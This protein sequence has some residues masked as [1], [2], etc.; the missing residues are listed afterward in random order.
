MFTKSARFY[1]ALYSWKD[2]PAEAHYIKETVDKRAPHAVSLLDVA[3]GTG[4]HLEH[5][6]DSFQVSGLD[7]D[8]ELLNIAR[9]RVPSADLH[10]GDMSSFD[11]GRRFDVVICMFSSIGYVRSLDRLRQAAYALATHMEPGGLLML[12][13][14]FGPG[15]FEDGRVDTLVGRSDDLTIER[16]ARSR[17]EG[18]DSIID[19]DYTVA[20]SSGVRERFSEHHVLGLFTRQEY[21]KAIEGAGLGHLEWDERGPTGR[22]L[23]TATKAARVEKRSFI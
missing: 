17:L 14:W 4:A 6:V 22:G 20:D 10:L 9:G 23:V 2:Y 5:L 11:L 16:V 19:F 13:P 1:D 18:R 21:N 3:C 15:E 8:P 12:E 7:L